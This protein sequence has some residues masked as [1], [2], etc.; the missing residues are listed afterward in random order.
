M[1]RSFFITILVVFC[2]AGAADLPVLPK[3]VS[4]LQKIGVL[5]DQ[6][7]LIVNGDETDY[8]IYQSAVGIMVDGSLCTASLIDPEVLLTAGH[9]VYLY[10]NNQLIIDAV[11]DPDA[12]TVKAGANIMY[13]GTTIAKAVEVVKH[14]SWEGDLAWNAID[15]ALI[16][17]DRKVTTLDPFPVRVAPSEQEDDTGVI[18]GYGITSTGGYD[19]GVHRYGNTTILDLVSGTKALIEIGDPAGACQGDSGGPFLTRQFDKDV[20]SGVASFV[21]GECSATSGSYYTW[22]FQY[23]DWIE[24][25]IV[26]LTGHGFVSEESCGDDNDICD[27]GEQ[28]PCDQVDPHYAS[29]TN[30]TCNDG[31]YWWETAACVPDCGDGYVML[32]EVCDGSGT[33]CASLGQYQSGTSAPCKNDCTGYDTSVCTATDCGDGVKEGNEFCDTQITSCETL[34]TYPENYY[35]RCN[36]ACTGYIIE[37]CTGGLIICGN[38]NIDPF[39]ECDDSNTASGDGCS[40]KCKTEVKPDADA[41]SPD[42][43]DPDGDG[44]PEVD[45]VPTDDDGSIL[46]DE[47]VNDDIVTVDD[48]PTPDEVS[49]DTIAVMDDDAATGPDCGNG[50]LED[51][52]ECDDGN[53]KP[54]DGC[55]PD[56]T[57]PDVTPDVDTRP[58]RMVASDG[59]SCAVISF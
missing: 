21:T 52:E 7:P 35:A 15:L 11:S 4:P 36:D 55:N 32:P 19:S 16:H 22:V 51:G 46:P 48:A 58:F 18:V 9:C 40:S 45:I 3:M 10:E 50:V 37:D 12:V 43:A 2:L 34:G 41:V 14:S 44:D 47:A 54:A 49:P 6:T 29:T 53:M 26:D 56:C 27:P 23:R 13:G 33:D 8:E 57:L 28:T 30:A 5:D 20:V 59:C 24:S 39:E 31:C 1:K 25:V 42:G 17:L 38:G